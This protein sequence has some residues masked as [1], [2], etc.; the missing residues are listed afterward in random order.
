VVGAA[1]I[2]LAGCSSSGGSEAQTSPSID[3]AH[4]AAID[5]ANCMRANGNPSFPDP[6]QDETKNW[7]FPNIDQLAPPPACAS[8]AVRFRQ[9]F[10]EY[11]ISSEDMAKSRRY[12]ACMREHGFPTYPDP[13]AE[14][15]FPLSS[16]LRAVED[17]PQMR[18]AEQACTKY[19]PPR[20]PK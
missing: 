1:L 18:S 19:L 6:V 2:A 13:D 7:V 10:R 11:T 12:T 20:P 16:D 5:L 8:Q 15:N 9:S 4:R 3:A 17:S 14:G